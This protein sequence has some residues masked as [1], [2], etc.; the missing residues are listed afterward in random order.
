MTP[1]SVDPSTSSYR[2]DS[3][4]S[5]V[6]PPERNVV[7]EPERSA[8]G[9]SELPRLSPVSPSEHGSWRYKTKRMYLS[10]IPMGQ[11]RIN[12]GAST[13]ADNDRIIDDIG[14]F[15]LNYDSDD[16]PDGWQQFIHPE[17]QCYFVREDPRKSNIRF[18]T[19]VNLLD[20][21]CWQRVEAVCGSLSR[22]FD[23]C[24]VSS[25][26]D[27]VFSP[28]PEKEPYD[29]SDW[30]Y[31]A[32]DWQRCVT[33]WPKE[34]ESFLLT[35]AKREAYG[36][37]HLSLL[38]L[39]HFEC[40]AYASF[41]L[42]PLGGLNVPFGN[43]KV[44]QMPYGGQKF[45]S[46]VV[47]YESLVF[48]ANHSPVE[49][50]SEARWIVG[51]IMTHIH[52]TRFLDLHGQQEA[53]LDRTRRI[54]A[55][56]DSHGPQR[57]SRL[58]GLISMALFDWPHTCMVQLDKLYVDRTVAQALWD[59]LLQKM[60]DEWN[61]SLIPV[62]VLLGANMGFLTIQTIS[63]FASTASAVSTALC[64]GS[65]IVCRILTA[66]FPISKSG[67][68]GSILNSLETN[69]RS[70]FG[71]RGVAFA[72]S[73]PM[74]LFI[75]SIVFFVVA[76]LYQFSKILASW[77]ILGSTLLIVALLVTP[78]LWIEPQNPATTLSL[79]RRLWKRAGDA[80]KSFKGPCKKV[81]WETPVHYIKQ[82]WQY[83]TPS[84]GR[85][86]ESVSPVIS[87]DV[88]T[89][90]RSSASPAVGYMPSVTQLRM[91]FPSRWNPWPS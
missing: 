64:L 76:L 40:L 20:P 35:N 43:R 12:L 89:V 44:E 68:Q 47:L 10:N 29:S 11:N 58:F 26:I 39:E 77:V 52:G 70:L 55:Q 48:A 83:K 24:P 7:D 15:E 80:M 1:S 23:S 85:P 5:R 4:D 74:A 59:H 53:S 81:M 56:D 66:K 69:E 25:E 34:V 72:F 22:S 46:W 19:R 65:I 27:L 79:R 16:L 54:F 61:Q 60:H 3:A 9:E 50:P 33:F 49:E 71:L 31:Y 8:S 13:P 28:E 32:V 82:L 91:V 84:G 78:V 51:N 88:D 75:W 2:V 73:L 6:D 17:G 45:R 38:R 57:E 86:S 41:R 37:G 63:Q 87:P 42:H 18:V 21:G 90:P 36:M 67:S 30:R 14:P 62:T